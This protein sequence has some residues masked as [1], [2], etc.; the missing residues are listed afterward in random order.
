MSNRYQQTTGKSETRE[1]R[2]NMRGAC[3]SLTIE[4]IPANCAKRNGFAYLFLILP[5]RCKM[6]DISPIVGYN[7]PVITQGILSMYSFIVAK[8]AGF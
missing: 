5:D 7:E 8:V 1:N 6:L 3:V 2:I 4:I